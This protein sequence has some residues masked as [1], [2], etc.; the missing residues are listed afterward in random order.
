MHFPHCNNKRKRE[1]ILESGHNFL[2]RQIIELMV[3]WVLELQVEFLSLANFDKFSSG[4][5]ESTKCKG[6]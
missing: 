1:A 3:E 5:Q 2:Y 4:R 6:F